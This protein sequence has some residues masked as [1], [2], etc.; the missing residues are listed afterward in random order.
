MGSCLHYLD[1]LYCLVIHT[2]QYALSGGIIIHAVGFET[3]DIACTTGTY[4]NIV[5]YSLCKFFVYA[6]ITDRV[7]ILWSPDA[8]NGRPRVYIYFTSIMS[9]VVYC[10]IVTLEISSP[11]SEI[12]RNGH[13]EIGL[14][15]LASIPLLVFHVYVPFVNIFV[16]FMFLFP[17]LSW[18]LLDNKHKQLAYSLAMANFIALSTSTVNILVLILCDGRELGWVYLTVCVSDILFNVL[19]LFW[20]SSNDKRASVPA[21]HEKQPL[22]R[23]RSQ[24]SSSNAS[25]ASSRRTRDDAQRS[26]TQRISQGPHSLHRL[27]Q[28]SLNRPL[29]TSEMTIPVATPPRVRRPS[30]AS[31]VSTGPAP[32]TRSRASAHRYS[33]PASLSGQDALRPSSLSM[34]VTALV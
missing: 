13:C 15:L 26:S 14:K 31:V 30:R 7:Q 22:A 5:L 24:R 21:N 4:V 11:I 23:P 18:T 28:H 2:F 33:R 25:L 34:S 8:N 20:A 16:P 6:Y 32:S 9:A 10:V 19:S 29:E 27:S 1:V 17:L 3:S 12:N